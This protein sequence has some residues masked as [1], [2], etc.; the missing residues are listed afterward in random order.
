M[1][2]DIVKTWI[3]I[4]CR[5]AWTIW[6]CLDTQ[7]GKWC[8]LWIPLPMTSNI[9]EQPQWPA[10]PLH[11]R[12][13]AHRASWSCSQ[14]LLHLALNTSGFPHLHAFPA[15]RQPSSHVCHPLH[16]THASQHSYLCI[17]VV[18]LHTSTCPHA[19]YSVH[20]DTAAPTLMLDT[21]I[22]A[23]HPS[24]I[25]LTHITRSHDLTCIALCLHPCAP[26]WVLP[27]VHWILWD[28]IHCVVMSCSASSRCPPRSNCKFH[29]NSLHP[30]MPAYLPSPISQNHYSISAH[31]SPCLVVFNARHLSVQFFTCKSKMTMRTIFKYELQI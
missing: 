10:S 6:S 29:F 19:R 12:A 7:T 2:P 13:T 1:V 23:A 9:N 25:V 28:E 14:W 5:Y 15:S 8:H 31:R 21:S 16:A 22:P 17:I 30:N 20:H 3:Y 26:N 11:L 27:A 4:P 18:C 24:G